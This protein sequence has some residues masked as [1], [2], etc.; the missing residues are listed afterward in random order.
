M[1]IHTGIRQKMEFYTFT[2]CIKYTKLLI[3]PSKLLSKTTIYIKKYIQ[4]MITFTDSGGT[5]M[6]YLSHLSDLPKENYRI[7]EYWELEGT[8]EDHRVLL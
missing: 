3:L 4:E 8:H 7:T 5:D 2:F 6:W 1:Y